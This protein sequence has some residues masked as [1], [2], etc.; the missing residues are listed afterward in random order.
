[1]KAP[2]RITRA[3]PA[4]VEAISRRWPGWLEALPFGALQLDDGGAVLR[5]VAPPSEEPIPGTIG[6]AFFETV[7]PA[8]AG[9]A[10]HQRF[11]EHC[12]SGGVNALIEYA[13]ERLDGQA[14]VR[15]HIK[16]S[17]DSCWLYISRR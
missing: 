9:A 2:M 17:G 13:F 14:F 10:P 12:Q 15:F 3:D 11:L 7:A 6:A 1:M 5:Y 8:L 16:S 4:E